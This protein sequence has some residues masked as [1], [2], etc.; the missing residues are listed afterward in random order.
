[1]DAVSELQAQEYLYLASV[2]EPEVNSLRIVV[3]AARGQRSSAPTAHG[4]VTGAFPIQ[5]DASTPTFEILFASYVGYLVRNESYASNSPS[6]N[7]R[8][9]LFR[10]YDTSE[11]LRFIR[12]TTIASDDYP[13]PLTHAAIVCLDHVIDVVSTT[14]PE[15]RLVGRGMGV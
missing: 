15:V 13:G 3:H 14:T 9:N 8:G 7:W 1:M 10:T 5:P 2:D 12:S 6:D 4:P 11:Y